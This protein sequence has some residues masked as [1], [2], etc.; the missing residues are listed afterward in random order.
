MIAGRKDCVGLN[1]EELNT[2]FDGFLAV[3]SFHIWIIFFFFGL[4]L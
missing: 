1:L 3:L 2:D 4:L